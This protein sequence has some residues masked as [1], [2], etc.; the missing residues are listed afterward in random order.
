M[1][2]SVSDMAGVQKRMDL[3]RD[4]EGSA[5]FTIISQHLDRGASMQ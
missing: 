3:G 2:M 4:K 1:H 5:L